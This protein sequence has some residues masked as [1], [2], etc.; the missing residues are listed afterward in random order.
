VTKSFSTDSLRLDVPDER[1]SANPLRHSPRSA[2][3][4]RRLFDHVMPII[5]SLQPRDG[6][7]RILDIGGAAPYWAAARDEL[8]TLG[9]KIVLLNQSAELGV[10]EFMDDHMS[11][12]IGDARAT[13]YADGA[14]DFVHSSSVIEHVGSWLDMRAMAGEI[15]RLAPVYYVQ[16]PYFWFPYEPHYKKPFFHWLPEQVRARWMMAKRFPSWPQAPS[17][18]HAVEWVQRAALLDRLQ[19]QALFPD[20]KIVNERVMGLTKSLM[21]IRQ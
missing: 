16:T 4:D 12:E 5:R 1:A 19:F 17:V 18:L 8:R 20:A 2:F 21:A 10:T 13:D 6:A 3:R 11:F 9:C 15:R 7:I 14:F